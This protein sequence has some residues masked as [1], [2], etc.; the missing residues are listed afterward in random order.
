MVERKRDP[1]PGQQIGNDTGQQD[2][3]AEGNGDPE[4][5]MGDAIAA[6]AADIAQPGTGPERLYRHIA[7]G[8]EHDQ[9]ADL[10]ELTAGAGFGQAAKLLADG[11]GGALV[12]A[13]GHQEEDEGRDRDDDHRHAGEDQAPA[14]GLGRPIGR[15]GGGNGA[16]PAEG[17][18]AAIAKRD[19]LGRQPQ[20]HG[21][22][23]GHQTAGKTQAD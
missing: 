10:P 20:R 1:A 4:Q 3:E 11:G 18:D 22:E 15:H 8:G 12:M 16:E 13:F 21:L 14:K 23:R 2:A 6:E 7:A 9:R 5:A 17:H 19:A